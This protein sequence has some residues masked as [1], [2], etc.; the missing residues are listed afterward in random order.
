MLPAWLL[1]QPRARHREPASQGWTGSPAVE[2]W[3]R[4]EVTRVPMCRGLR[5]GP[6]SC[7]VITDGNADGAESMKFGGMA[8]RRDNHAT[9]RTWSIGWP[10]GCCSYSAR[11]AWK[12]REGGWEESPTTV[13]ASNTWSFERER[14]RPGSQQ[15][16]AGP[17]RRQV[18]IHPRIPSLADQFERACHCRALSLT[19]G[20]MGR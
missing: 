5:S 17:A 12:R 19:S 3:W 20:R 13:L 1:T 8:T 11:V 9:G 7:H 2:P 6:S 4:A 10:G 14:Q 15:V 18:D 16:G